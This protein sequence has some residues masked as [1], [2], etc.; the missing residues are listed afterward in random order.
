MQGARGA[1]VVSVDDLL[2]GLIGGHMTQHTKP[3]QS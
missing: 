1:D 3:E 2:V